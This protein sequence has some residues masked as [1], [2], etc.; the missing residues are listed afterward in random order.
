MSDD[1]KVV[2]ITAGR[3]EAPTKADDEPFELQ[4]GTCGNRSFNIVGEV[5]EDG[6]TFLA[7]ICSHAPCQTVAG[8][9]LDEVV[10]YTDDDELE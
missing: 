8:V 7:F 9:V 6:D 3:K 1:K 10:E 2:P 4:C 5:D